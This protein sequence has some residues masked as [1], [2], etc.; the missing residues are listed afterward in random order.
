MPDRRWT[1]PDRRLPWHSG[2]PARRIAR[3]VC[4]AGRTLG[5]RLAVR[6]GRSRAVRGRR[7]CRNR[8]CVRAGNATEAG[9]SHAS[10]SAACRIAHSTGAYQA[11]VESHELP[12]QSHG[13][14]HFPFQIAS[15]HDGRRRGRLHRAD[16]VRTCDQRHRCRIGSETVSGRVSVRFDGGRER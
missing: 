5:I 2:V 12:R 10:E 3:L 8:V 15:D 1:R 14:Q 7:A 16:C 13:A 6:N 4:D 11:V 9:Q